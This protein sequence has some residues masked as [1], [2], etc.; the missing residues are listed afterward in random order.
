MPD[1]APV[2]GAGGITPLLVVGLVG[3]MGGL[4]VDPDAA[5]AWTVVVAL[6]AVTAGAVRAEW[7]M[8]LVSQVSSSGLD[9][10]ALV[11]RM[12]ALI[13]AFCSSTDIESPEER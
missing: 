12:C 2:A 13:A 9:P 3:R 1:P 11:R 7:Y 10:V 5:G 6:G 8:L 4:A